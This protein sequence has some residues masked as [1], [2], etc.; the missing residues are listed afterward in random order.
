LVT[1]KRWFSGVFNYP[2]YSPDLAL[3]FSCLHSWRNLS[4]KNIF[5]VKWAAFKM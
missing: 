2:P 3:V 5:P 1:A 4:G